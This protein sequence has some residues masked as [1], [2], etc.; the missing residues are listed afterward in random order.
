LATQVSFTTDKPRPLQSLALWRF[1]VT[2]EL[3]AL[4]AKVP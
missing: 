3:P 1:F 4:G 2:L